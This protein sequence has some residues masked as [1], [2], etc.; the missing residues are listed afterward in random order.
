MTA[1]TP[2]VLKSYFQTGDK[3]TQSDYTDLIDSFVPITGGGVT[4]VSGSLLVTGSAAVSGPTELFSTLTVHNNVS[5]SGNISLDSGNIALTGATGNASFSGTI[6]AAALSLSGAFSA[7]T[8]NA[9]N[10]NITNILV[11]NDIQASTFEGTTATFT[12]AVTANALHINT[13]ISAQSLNVTADI[14]AATGTVYASATRSQGG[15]YQQVTIVSAAGTAQGTAAPCSA[16]ICRLRGVVDGSTTGYGLMANRI[17]WVQYLYNESGASANLW[18]P[19]GGTINGSAANAVM[20]LVANG[21][22]TVLHVQA[23]AYAVF[24]DSST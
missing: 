6:T 10:L 21:R 23:S 14:S 22:Y 24:K 15:Y 3:P 20:P 2:T 9:F 5:V 13:K 7:A 12:G 17:G 1:Q 18:P 16:A 11:G 8:I 4:T 19:T